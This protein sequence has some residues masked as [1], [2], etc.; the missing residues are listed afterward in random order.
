[1]FNERGMFM[2]KYIDY[3]HNTIITEQELKAEYETL[4]KNGETKQPDF[5]SYEKEV[6]SKNGTLEL[7]APDYEIE[8]LRKWTAVKIAA[9][10][11]AKYEDVL[12]VLRKYNVHGNWTMYEINNRPVDIDELQEMVEQELGY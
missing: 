6:A 7:I 10:S 9:Q 2:K 5:T 12:E 11:E 3:E 8:N 4:R 1:M